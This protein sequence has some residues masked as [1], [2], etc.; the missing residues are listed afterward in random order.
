M[1]FI[2]FG[3]KVFKVMDVVC[4]IDPSITQIHRFKFGLLKSYLFRNSDREIFVVSVDL[5][6]SIRLNVVV[7]EVYATSLTIPESDITEEVVLL[8]ENN[9]R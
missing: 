2:N 5:Q 9:K 7:Q 1:I 3:F 4:D 6:S 8:T